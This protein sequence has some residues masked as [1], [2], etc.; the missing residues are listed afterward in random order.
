MAQTKKEKKDIEKK[1]RQTKKQRTMELEELN[2]EVVVKL[3][4]MSIVRGSDEHKKLRTELYAIRKELEEL[5]ARKTIIVS[6]D[7]MKEA[8]D[9]GEIK[10]KE[11]K[12]K[13]AK[14]KTNHT[15]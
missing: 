1:S 3:L 12:K 11:A 15:F 13:K 14:S 6:K 8:A 10:K 7:D 5:G 2:N 9:K 4:N